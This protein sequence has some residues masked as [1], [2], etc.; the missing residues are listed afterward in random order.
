MSKATVVQNKQNNNHIRESV[1]SKQ[2][3]PD[4]QVKQT[5]SNEELKRLSGFFGLLLRVSLRT[6]NRKVLGSDTQK[7]EQQEKDVLM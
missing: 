7:E 3:L 6:N 5:L 2:E 1:M 4:A